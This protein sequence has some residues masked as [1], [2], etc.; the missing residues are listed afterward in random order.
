MVLYSHL[1]RSMEGR[2]IEG[3]RF[4]KQALGQAPPDE[5]KGVSTRSEDA[6]HPHHM[7]MDTNS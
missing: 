5:Y 2:S 3:V 1:N 4:L 6:R 7:E